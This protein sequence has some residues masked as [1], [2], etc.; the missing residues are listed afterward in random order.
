MFKGKKRQY[1]LYKII[2]VGR[3]TSFGRNVGFKI[4]GNISKNS[5]IGVGINCGLGIHKKY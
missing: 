1:R 3:K 4:I 5:F 2:P